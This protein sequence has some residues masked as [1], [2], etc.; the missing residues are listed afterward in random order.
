MLLD[1]VGDISPELQAKL[2]RF[3]QER[4]FERLG[5]TK[6]IQVNVRVLAATNR[7][8][9]AAIQEG[10]LPRRPLYRLNVVA[11]SLPPLRERKEDIPALAYFF[12]RRFAAETKKRVTEITPEAQATPCL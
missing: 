9:A 3:L 2:L 7:D 10:S 6:A 8:L 5:G 1:E 12:L 4:E 11:I